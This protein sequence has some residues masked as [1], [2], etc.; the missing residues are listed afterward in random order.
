MADDKPRTFAS[1]FKRFFG[2]GLGVLLPSVLTLWILVKAYQFVDS[3]IAQPINAGIRAGVAEGAEHWPT[4]GSPFLPT[5]E[6]IDTEVVRRRTSKTESDDP[7]VIRRELT[8][9][10][11]D[12]WWNRHALGL[13]WIGILVAVLSVYFAG[14]LLGGFLGRRVQKQFERVITSVPLFKQIYPYVKQVVDFLFSDDKP[15]KF[16]RVVTVEYPRKGIWAVGLVTGGTMRSIEHE[17]G[18]ALTIFIPSSPTPFTGYTITVPRGEVH[19]LPISID[20]ALRFTIS[21]GVLVP[22]HEALPE[23]DSKDSSLGSEQQRI[24]QQPDSPDLH[25]DPG[26][27]KEP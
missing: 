19:E 23:R 14:R 9:T 12:E 1:D 7:V 6:L 17:S 15:M 20:E 25:S 4:L 5:Q 11:V 3:A 24:L 8:R 13:D 16:N 10:E 2:R 18:D 27:I 22:P 26:E 21:G